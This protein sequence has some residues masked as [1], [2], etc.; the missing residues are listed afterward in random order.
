MTENDRYK[1]LKVKPV[2]DFFKV[3]TIVVLASIALI[4][5][6]G[7]LSDTL[8]A[9]IPIEVELKL[10]KKLN[11]SFFAQLT[12]ILTPGERK[13]APF[14]KDVLKKLGEKADLKQYSLDIQF[15]CSEI[16]T[17]Y[18]VMGG[19]IIVTSGFLD[20]L[21]TENGLAFVLAHE[22]GHFKHRHHLKGLGKGIILGSVLSSLGLSGADQ[23]LTEASDFIEMKYS[24]DEER[25]ADDYAIELMRRSYGSLA[26]ADEL[27]THLSKKYY[28]DPLDFSSSHPAT[29]ERIK[30][31][32]SLI[33]R[34]EPDSQK[35]PED[36]KLK[37]K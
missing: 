33:S 12:R 34:S 11:G 15:V 36:L 37:C 23:L 14:L 7:F 4:Y 5:G 26:G 8:T 17:A 32:R 28:S 30:K 2:R 27:F 9:K 1:H 31:L 21:Q 13:E 35:I 20:Y 29:E 3:L 6:L 18:A 22:L 19:Q 25:V 10:F 16:P 24:R